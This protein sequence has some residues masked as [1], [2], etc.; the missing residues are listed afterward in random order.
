MGKLY[1]AAVLF[2]QQ[3]L[4]SKNVMCRKREEMGYWKLNCAVLKD[5][6]S[7]GRVRPHSQRGCNSTCRMKNLSL[8]G[9]NHDQISITTSCSIAHQILIGDSHA[10]SKLIIFH[11][12]KQTRDLF[13]QH[14][15]PVAYIDY[16]SKY[17]NYSSHTLS[18]LKMETD[19][20][21]LHAEFHCNGI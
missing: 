15:F 16:K 14:T 20:L 2:G 6:I 13:S 9:S 19:V 7:R 4:V 8:R 1:G 3:T 11:I 21:L 12:I 5:M 17:Y 10:I 18:H